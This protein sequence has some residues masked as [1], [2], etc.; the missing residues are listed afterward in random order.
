MLDA[1]QISFSYNGD[2]ILRGLDLHV[3]DGQ[4]LCI[5][6]PNGCGKTTL[7]RLLSGVVKPSV[8]RITINGIDLHN[9]KPARRAKLVSIMPQN[10]QLPIGFTVLDYVL[11]GRNPHLGLL[12]WEGKR[13]FLIARRAMA[14]TDTEE[15]AERK[16][17]TLSGG[18]LQRVMVAL[19]ITQE[20]PVMLLDEPTSN[21]DLAHQTD[22]LD[23]VRDVHMERGGV[24]IIAMHDLTLAAQYCDKI[25]ML[26]KG[27]SYSEGT[28]TEVLTPSNI[29]SVYQTKVD[30]LLHPNGATPVILPVSA[31]KLPDAEQTKDASP[32]N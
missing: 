4:L 1:Q 8:G 25:V 23:L 11:L 16:L 19:S 30:I 10:P 21:L 32:S 15:L 13:D 14:L 26:C 27:R 28:P 6:G 29:E 9:V 31:K 12:Q 18:E 22:I 2:T 3:T 17:G 24:T 7:L 5:V 20:S